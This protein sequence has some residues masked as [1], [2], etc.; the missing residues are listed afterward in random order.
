M[1]NLK[2]LRRFAMLA[3]QSG[4]LGSHK[5][6]HAKAGWILKELLATFLKLIPVIEKPLKSTKKNYLNYLIMIEQFHSSLQSP[7]GTS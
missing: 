4:I 2:D 1:Q 5:T 6:W 7:S 3:M